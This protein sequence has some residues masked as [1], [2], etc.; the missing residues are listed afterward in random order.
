[1]RKKEPPTENGGKT[2]Y[3]MHLRSGELR[4]ITVPSNWRVTF[5]PLVPGKEGRG[6]PGLRF[7][8]GDNQRACFTDVESFR[9]ASIDIEE[10]VT[11]EKQQV[12]RKETPSG[13]KD[14]VVSA[15]VSEWRNPDAP[16]DAEKEDQDFLKI[17]DEALRD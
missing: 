9:D 13:S 7:Y 5:G 14:Y 2:T 16:E 11:R 1:M 3:I 15:R 6:S 8:E 17:T 12:M 10:R 4:R